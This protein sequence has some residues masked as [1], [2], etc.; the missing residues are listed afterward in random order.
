MKQR[1]V[2]NNVLFATFSIVLS[3]IFLVGCGDNDVRF[4]REVADF[5]REIN[6]LFKDPR[7]TPL[8]AEERSNFEGLEFF[9]ADPKYRVLAKAERIAGK[10]VEIPTTTDR[11]ARYRPYVKLKFELEGKQ[12]ELT[13]YANIGFPTNQ[14]KDELEPLF[15]PFTDLTNGN[16]TYGGGRY[17]ELER[18]EGAEWVLD[19]NHAYN[20]FCAYNESFSCPLPP[21]ENDINAAIP[22]GVKYSSDIH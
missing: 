13:A 6:E 2:K 21:S 19:F 12:H 7:R 15:L 18:Q 1:W 17:I 5:Q 11:V 9:E 16:E 22:V 10:V 3:G 20:P 8:S 4:K 14:K